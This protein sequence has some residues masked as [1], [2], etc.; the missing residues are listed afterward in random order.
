MGDF[1][2]T[3]KTG[4]SFADAEHAKVA[5]RRA[6]TATLRMIGIRRTKRKE[7]QRRDGG[8]K[9]ERGEERNVRLKGQTAI[10]YKICLFTVF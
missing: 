8:R 1:K 5:A 3:L 7:G 2:P 6:G 9:W 10:K 4:L